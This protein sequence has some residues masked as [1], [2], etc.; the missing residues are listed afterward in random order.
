[1]DLTV[2]TI[3]KKLNGA[4]WLLETR[5]DKVFNYVAFPLILVFITMIFVHFDYMQN[6]TK[7]DLKALSQQLQ[8]KLSDLNSQELQMRQ[9]EERLRKTISPLSPEY[10]R[11]V[12]KQIGE[13]RDGRYKVMDEIKSITNQAPH[14]SWAYNLYAALGVISEKEI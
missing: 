2:K 5:V 3:D 14:T 13:I 9:Q 6:S 1:M 11:E 10:N 8:T 12:R 7:R 4:F